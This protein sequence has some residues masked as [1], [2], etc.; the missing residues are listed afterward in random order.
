MPLI[1][2]LLPY[3]FWGFVIVMVTVPMGG[4]RKACEGLPDLCQKSLYPPKLYYSASHPVFQVLLTN[5]LLSLLF[6]IKQ[7]N[8]VMKQKVCRVHNRLVVLRAK[9]LC[10]PVIIVNTAVP[11][12]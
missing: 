2:A 10:Q 7:H 4:L 11:E 6:A 1:A 5:L 8:Y 9:P 12:C 3:G